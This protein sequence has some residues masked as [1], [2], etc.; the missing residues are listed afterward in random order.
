MSKTRL[1]IIKKCINHK[2]RLQNILKILIRDCNKDKILINVN[3]YPLLFFII[4]NLDNIDT[5]LFF[6]CYNFIVTQLNDD[7]KTLE[8]SECDI[9]NDKIEEM[10]I[11]DR[12]YIILRTQNYKRDDNLFSKLNQKTLNVSLLIKLMSIYKPTVD[13]I[14][15]LFSF[16]SF[17]H[18]MAVSIYMISNKLPED[19]LKICLFDFVLN[20]T[21]KQRKQIRILFKKYKKSKYYRSFK[22]LQKL[23]KNVNEQKD[24]TQDTEELVDEQPHE[25]KETLQDN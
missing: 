18:C 4:F 8:T 21:A 11:H 9:I 10:C 23:S 20:C 2:D 12:T 15:K 22:F 19:V 13:E 6:D 7:N 16:N 5:E 24:D 3:L 25:Q 17:Y 14:K 1:Y